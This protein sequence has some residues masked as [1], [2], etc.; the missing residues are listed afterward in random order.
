MPLGLPPCPPHAATSAA[1]PASAAAAAATSPTAWAASPATL[2]A[3]AAATPFPRAQSDPELLVM[4]LLQDACNEVRRGQLNTRGAENFLECAT[5]SG[6]V[7]DA[8]S[9]KVALR[10]SMRQPCPS[11]NYAYEHMVVLRNDTTSG[12][13]AWHVSLIIQFPTYWV[14]IDPTHLQYD[15]DKDFHLASAEKLRALHGVRP[16]LES[17][18]P[19]IA[20]GYSEQE[21]LS[22]WHEFIRC[23]PKVRSIGRSVKRDV[24]KPSISEGD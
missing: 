11:I 22:L 16:Q 18:G 20:H 7:Q 6:K 3:S 4:P 9:G 13:D 24:S 10:K 21:V 15:I 23:K 17:F 2:F 19:W 5:Y 1:T 12:K 14:L 8:F